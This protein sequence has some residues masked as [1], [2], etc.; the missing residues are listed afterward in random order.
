MG[1][2]LLQNENF[3]VIL[4]VI[5]LLSGIE[6]GDLLTTTALTLE[7]FHLVRCLTHISHRYFPP[8]R[9]LVISSATTYRDVLMELIAEIN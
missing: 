4:L 6:N 8:G 1:C 9:N 2:V 3:E 7:E 5:Q